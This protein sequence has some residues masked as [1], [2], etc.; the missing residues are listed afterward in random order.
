MDEKPRQDRTWLYVGLGFALLW[1]AI[2]A[3]LHP[4]GEGGLRAPALGS[5]APRGVADYSWTLRDL[6]G[7]AVSLGDFK[8]RPIVLNIWATWCT[9]CRAEMPSLARLA[10]DPRL[11]G[12]A[13]LGVTDEKPTDSVKKYA[14]DE[15][16]GITVLTADGVPAAFAT[17]GIPAT[18]IVAADGGIVLSHVGA[19]RWDD[20]AVVDYLD[21]LVRKGVPKGS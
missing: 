9:P 3:F 5:D 12:V 19:A 6:D 14:R 7:K 8:G 10:A 11:K 13:F 16:K 2:L 18:F 21:T 4:G 15:M 17:E 1:A 20:P